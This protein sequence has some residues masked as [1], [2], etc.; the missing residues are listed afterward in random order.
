[1]VIVKRG[2]EYVEVS[3]SAAQEMF[4][5]VTLDGRKNYIIMGDMIAL[6]TSRK[7]KRFARMPWL[8]E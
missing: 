6:C 1:M 7:G 3:L 8:N 2:S 5:T 4:P